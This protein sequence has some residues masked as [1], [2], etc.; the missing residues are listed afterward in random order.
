MSED[1]LA[2]RVEKQVLVEAV[3]HASRTLQTNLAEPILRAITLTADEDS[4]VCAGY[5]N[6]VSNQARFAA[7]VFQPGK[8][9]VAGKLLDG[10]TKNLPNQLVSC[11]VSNNQLKLTC[12]SSRF[13]IPLIPL[14]NYPQLPKMPEVIGSVDLKEFQRAVTQ[15]SS[16]AASDANDTLPMLTGMQLAIDGSTIKLTATDRFRLTVRR[17]QWEPVDSNISTKI[18]VPASKLV[19]VKYLDATGG[20]PLQLALGSSDAEQ[21][22]LL[23][24]YKYQD[25]ETTMRLLDGDF[26]NVDPLIPAIHQSMAAVNINELSAACKRVTVVSGSN[27]PIRLSFSTDVVKVSAQSS[28]S[29][30][31]EEAVACQYTSGPDAPD[32]EI[33]FN[34]DYLK[35][36]LSAIHTDRVVFG[37]NESS[38]PAIMI[39]EPEALPSANAEGL[40]DSPATDFVYLLMPVR[41][42]G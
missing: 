18:L 7:E 29:G 15:V 21:R 27:D 39:P 6:E 35:G 28:D 5:D 12:G 1:N 34:P 32:F 2:F 8:I 9:A 24:G 19:P 26:P 41:L 42:P 22:N 30:H 10:I 33:A 25:A 38:R 14:E 36:G 37:F 11:E 31:A 23:F 4:V 20:E 16:A 17:M 13:D 40:Y 3:N